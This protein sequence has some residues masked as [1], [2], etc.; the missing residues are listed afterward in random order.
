MIEDNDSVRKVQPLWISNQVLNNT[1]CIYCMTISHINSI[2]HEYYKIQAQE[3]NIY[4]F[5]RF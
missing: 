2:F 1:L 3:K 4:L 5:K